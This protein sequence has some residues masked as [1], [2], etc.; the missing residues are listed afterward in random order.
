[1][2]AKERRPEKAFKDEI[3]HRK[4]TRT[5]SKKE[6]KE[7]ISSLTPPYYLNPLEVLDWVKIQKE[8]TEKSEK[9]EKEISS[10]NTPGI[11]EVSI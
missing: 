4:M 7:M 10:S 3:K 6:E 5:F 1:M 9:L 8:K 11:I 2:K